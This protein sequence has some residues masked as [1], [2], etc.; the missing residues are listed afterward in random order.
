MSSKHTLMPGRYASC[1][2]LHG[3]FPSIAC[4]LLHWL[5]LLPAAV[6]LALNALDTLQQKVLLVAGEKGVYSFFP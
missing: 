4:T 3:G 5:F 1:E 6:R 2:E